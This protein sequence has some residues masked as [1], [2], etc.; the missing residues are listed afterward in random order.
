MITMIF[1]NKEQNI[2]SSSDRRMNRAMASKTAEK[3]F[4]L[5]AVYIKKKK[6]FHNT[7]LCISTCIS[8]LV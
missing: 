8:A 5:T 1:L 6:N 7:D 4:P 2:P 3:S